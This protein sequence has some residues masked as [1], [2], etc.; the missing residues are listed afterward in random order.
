MNVEDD[1]TVNSYD[2]NMSVLRF[3]FTRGE[4]AVLGHFSVSIFFG[5]SRR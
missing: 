5:V 2:D 4:S 3:L 1:R